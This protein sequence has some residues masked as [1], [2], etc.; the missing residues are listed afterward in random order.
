[1]STINQGELLNGSWAKKMILFLKDKAMILWKALFLE[2]R[3]LIY[4]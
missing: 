3:I 1:M 4:S 2:K